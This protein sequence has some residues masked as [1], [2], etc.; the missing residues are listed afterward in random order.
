MY[1]KIYNVEILEKNYY[2]QTNT[3]FVFQ[4]THLVTK[5]S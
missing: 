3:K 4:N 5:H 2:I 1:N